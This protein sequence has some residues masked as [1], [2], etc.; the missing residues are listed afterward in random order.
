[1]NDTLFCSLNSSTI[2]NQIHKAQYSICYAAP[3]IHLEPAKAM[4]EF[5][6]RIGPEFITVC[7]DFD[8]RVLRM[9][10]GDLEAVE[11]LH[12]AG[13]N[14]SSTRG[15]RTG[16][17][18]VDHKGY[19]FTPNA[20]YLE[21][22][23]PLAE[24]PNA[25]HLSHDQVI[26]ALARLSPSAKIIAIALA[27]TDE[28]KRRIKNQGIEV[29][30][31][32]VSDAE[33]AEV[34]RRLEEAPPASFD[35][36]RQVRVFNAYLQYVELKLTGAAIQRRRL[37]IPT[38]LQKLGGIKEIEG[39]L[40]TTFDLIQKDSEL[41]SKSLEDKLNE[42]RKNFTRSLGKDHGRVILKAAKALFE[43]RLSYFRDE[44]KVHQVKIENELQSHL[45]ES[46]KQ[47][48]D[49][50]LP[51]VLENP[52]DEMRGQVLIFGKEQAQNWIYNELDRDFPRAAD[53]VQKIKLDVRYKDITF[54]TLNQNDFLKSLQEAFLHI[55]WEKTY[56]E[57]RAVG[58]II[59]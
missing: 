6:Q 41:S 48:V 13:I 30:S 5:A 28:E 14:V 15:L 7:L 31:S 42:I 50:F 2:A 33:Y 25:L 32:L 17:I 8:E 53:L 12:G 11:I 21:A 38:S 57:F 26:E 54:E 56:N 46:R 16:L 10:F 19:I 47:L 59:R 4:V 35:V 51:R 1:M 40:I 3:G 55:D 37:T 52:P 18:I 49:Y 22:D 43:E 34:R 44:V 9:G 45:D 58:E 39:R 20:L 36:A 29:P 23:Q 27:K 24:A